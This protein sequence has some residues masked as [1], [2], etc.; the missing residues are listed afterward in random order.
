[1]EKTSRFVYQIIIT[2]GLILYIFV[3]GLMIYGENFWPDERNYTDFSLE[4]YSDGWQRLDADGSYKD[5]V[6]PGEYE[7]SVSD[8]LVI[9]K[10]ITGVFA[11][12][13]Y[14]SFDS[15]KQDVYAYINDK[16]VYEYSTKDTRM[17][18]NN[19]P[20]ALMFIPVKKADEGRMLRVELIGNNNYSGVLDKISIGTQLGITLDLFEKEK[21]S[22]FLAGLLIMLGLI[23]FIIG[24]IVKLSYNKTLPLFYSGWAVMCA[25]LWAL[26]ESTTRQFI[27]PNFSLISYIT[28]ISLM[29]LPFVMSMYFDRLQECRYRIFYMI[30]EVLTI[31]VGYLGIVLQFFNKTDLS[32]V[33]PFAFIGILLAIGIFIVTLISDFIQGYIKRLLPETV[34]IIGAMIAGVVQI[35]AYKNHPTSMNR[36]IILFG[37][38]FMIVMSYIKSLSN[39]RIME[40]DMYAA[41]QAQEAST[42]FLTRMSHEMRTPI[43]AILGMN[44]MILRESKEENILDYARDVNGAGNYLLSIVNEVLD[45]AKVNAGKIEIEEEDYELL[46]MVRE[47]YAL[48]RP[49]AKASRLA[50]E[51]DMSDVLPSVLRGDKERIIQVIT[52]L[53]TNAVKY[54]PEGR[55]TLSVNGKIF[56]GR[57]LLIV[58]VADTGIGVEEENIPYLFDSF[59]RVNEFQHKKIEG[60]GLGLTITKQLID[61]MDGSISVESEVGKGTTFT[62]VIPQEIRSIEPCGVFSMGPNGDRRVADRHEVFDILGKILVIDDVAINLRVFSMLL[63][64]TDIAVDTAISGAEAIE[65]IKSTKYDMIFI[66]HLMPGMDGVELKGILDSLESNP[67]KDT[68]LIMQ[69]ANAV[70]GAKEEYERLGFDDYIE[71]PIKEEELRKLLRKYIL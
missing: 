52:N 17:F 54:T 27:A 23:A 24:V 65:K 26:S 19:S 71:K 37:L 35:I 33:L 69:T 21:L 32:G 64:N 56:E 46:D 13:L 62:V 8:R 51:V 60:T 47:C 4:D 61:L 41:V 49:R 25:G 48:V 66:D 3:V 14:V 16:L 9:Q 45:L 20:G 6:V 29:M 53:L 36:V 57:L 40:R 10:K 67:N 39:V 42:A 30:S 43:N 58:K 70:V 5:I 1:M 44:K 22:L 34:G 15:E 31:F 68:P 11:D 7:M 38:L 50:F 28:Y 59:R 55:I 63:K 18:G 12:R 2:C